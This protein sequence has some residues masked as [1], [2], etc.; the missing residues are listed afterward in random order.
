MTN[1]VRIYLPLLAHPQPAVRT[2]ACMILLGTYGQQAL[3]Y[4]RRLLDD[5]DAQVRQQARLALLAVKELTDEPLRL[6]PFKGMYVECLGHLRV[7]VGNREIQAEGWA[8]SGGGRAGWQKVQAVLAYL[9]H[10]GRRGTSRETL[11]AAIWGGEYSAT[12][13]ARTLTVLRQ[14]FEQDPAGAAIAAQALSIEPDFCR[15]AP[16][17]YHTDVQ[18]FEHVFSL[19]VQLEHD[20]DLC[21]AVPL[22]QQALL[23][24][25][26]PY[27]ADVARAAQWGR[28]RRDHLMSSFVIAAERQAEYFFS[29]RQFRQCQD[30]CAL[31]LDADPGADEAM[32]WLLRAYTAQGLR[33]EREQAYRAYLRATQ[34]NA[35]AV[36]G[37]DDPVV[38]VYRELVTGGS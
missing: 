24:Y 1:L 2:Q 30:V 14:A 36:G 3:T 23:L 22:Y 29:Q 4:L 28:Q 7:Y 16:D 18:M 21:A 12:S 6:R 15:L 27:M 26:G 8:A 19:A 31:A 9:L 5:S 20:R 17:C 35:L 11:G 10:C 25:A 32:I 34:T 38:R 33:A 13:L 37:H